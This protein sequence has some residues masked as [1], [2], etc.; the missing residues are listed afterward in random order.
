M[1]PFVDRAIRTL[2]TNGSISRWQKKWFNIDFARLHVL[3]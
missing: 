1:K 2:T 3:K